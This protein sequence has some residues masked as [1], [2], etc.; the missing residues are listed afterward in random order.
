[1]SQMED[2]LIDK[3]VITNRSLDHIWDE[4]DVDEDYVEK[5]DDGE[6]VS[7]YTDSDGKI[8]V[9]VQIGLY[10]YYELILGED[11][12]LVQEVQNGSGEG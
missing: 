6:I 12:S 5:G 10:I 3:S 8:R 1:M 9:D 7:A 2:E 4:H 11:V